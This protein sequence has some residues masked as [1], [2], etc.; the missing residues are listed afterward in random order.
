MEPAPV[1]LLLPWHASSRHE[2]LHGRIEQR[3]REK[4]ERQRRARAAGVCLQAKRAGPKGR[5]GKVSDAAI[6]RRLKARMLDNLGRLWTENPKLSQHY[7]IIMFYR[8][9]RVALGQGLGG[10]RA[11]VGW[12]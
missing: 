8:I 3:A 7:V 10:V 5:S 1:A 12:R 9:L 2:V 6:R 4:E 11:G